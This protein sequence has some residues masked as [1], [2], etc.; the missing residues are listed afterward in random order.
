M[1]AHI[2]RISAELEKYGVKREDRSL[3]LENGKY[4]FRALVPI[5]GNGARREYVGV[6]PTAAEAVKQ[7]IDQVAVDRK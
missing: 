3:A 4:T 1:R 6:G 5:S 7:V 2:P